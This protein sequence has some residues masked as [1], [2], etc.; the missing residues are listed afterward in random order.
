MEHLRLDGRTGEGGGQILRSALTLSLL[1]Q[2]PF[3]LQH[4]RG[5]RPK[6]GLMRQH[7][8]CVRAAQAICGAQVDGAELGS[9][10]LLFEPGTVKPGSYRFDVGSAGSTT[11]VFQTVLLPLLGADGPSEVEFI[12]GTHNP[13]APPLT[14]IRRSF[15]PLLQRMGADVTVD[16]TQWGF[17][18]VGGGCWRAVIQPSRLR[19]LEI[20]A[21][22]EL[23]QSR[24][25]T[26]VNGVHK[27]VAER[28]LSAY[29]RLSN[30]PIDE[31][32]IRQP[33]AASPGNLLAHDLT[34][35]QVG[36]CF[37]ELGRPRV[38]AEQVAA[39][40]WHQVEAYLESGSVLEPCLADQI[41]LPLLVAGGGR[42]ACARLSLHGETNRE[43]IRLF[44]G[45]QIGL[46]EGVLSL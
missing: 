1:T 19:P 22:G 45:R 2:R 8:S 31:Q 16:T 38:S 6:P 44:T 21:R 5:K 17:M 14:F 41:M 39:N 12:G 3:E 10:T 4:I 18:P 9:S 32:R 35:D 43:I 15:L 42:F 13:L 11:L 30:I 36:Y 20:L 34:F 23:Q 37:T 7:L 40:L 29:A 33:R 25:S 46:G 26:Y 27:G 24:V 28:E